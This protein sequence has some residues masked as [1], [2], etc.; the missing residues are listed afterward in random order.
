MVDVQDIDAGRKGRE[1]ERRRRSQIKK[2]KARM[3]GKTVN[4]VVI[5]FKSTSIVLEGK[6]KVQ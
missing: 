5:S 6:I 2:H 1:R 4:N 3:R